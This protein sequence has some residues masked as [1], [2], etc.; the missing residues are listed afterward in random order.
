[1]NTN[2]TERRGTLCALYGHAVLALLV[3]Y[4]ATHIKKSVIVV[5]K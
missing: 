3:A 4:Q 2:P 5:D 1:M